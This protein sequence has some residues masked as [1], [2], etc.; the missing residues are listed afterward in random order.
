[1]R[2]D[3][4]FRTYQRFFTHLAA[5][6]ETLLRDAELG[7]SDLV[8]GSDEE[9]AL[10]LFKAI[11]CS[12]SDAKLI[13]CTWHLG[14]KSKTPAKTKLACLKIIKQI[15]GDFFGSDGL[16][17]LDMSVSFAQ[18]ATVI[19]SRFGEKVGTLCFLIK[20]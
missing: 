7:T 19:K 16:T 11:K 20:K 15:V 18:K 9:K 4:S 2:C 6:L 14:G 1:M 5:V 8:I 13:L 12:F 17:S 3:G 10:V